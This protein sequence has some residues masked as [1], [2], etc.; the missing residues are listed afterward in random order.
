MPKYRVPFLEGASMSS[1]TSIS[2]G[3]T[4][5]LIGASLLFATVFVATLATADERSEQQPKT[6]VFVCLHGSVKSQMAAAHFNQLAKERGL[7]FVAVSR[8]VAVD[9]SIPTR[10]RDGL[11]LEGLAPVD[12]VPRGLTAEEANSASK[13]FAFD[14]VPTERKG[15]ADVTYWSNVPPPRKTTARRVMQ[16]FGISTTFCRH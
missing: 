5:R 11:A 14:E 8:G 7:P 12:D 13:V 16:L 4:A 10:I 9:S 1:F 15:N 3:K 6:I 2:P